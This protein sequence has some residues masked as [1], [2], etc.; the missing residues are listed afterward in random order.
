MIVIRVMMHPGGDE[1]RA[2]EMATAV[3]VNDGTGDQT[4]GIY[5]GGF[6]TG[7]GQLTETLLRQRTRTF[8]GLRF[9]RQRKNVWYLIARALKESGYK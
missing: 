3:I 5:H 7:R 6:V 2:Y 4:T 8:V 9:P 1:S